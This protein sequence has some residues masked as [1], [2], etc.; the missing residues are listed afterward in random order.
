MVSIFRRIILFIK[1]SNVP[2]S[3]SLIK[4]GIK[5]LRLVLIDLKLFCLNRIIQWNKVILLYGAPFVSIMFMSH[6]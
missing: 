3:S 2:Q 4:E 1:F 5:S 6:I